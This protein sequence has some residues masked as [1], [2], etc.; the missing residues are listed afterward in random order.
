MRAHIDILWEPYVL[1]V[2]VNGLARQALQLAE[3]TV[4]AFAARASETRA[5]TL[6]TDDRQDSVAPGPSQVRVSVCVVKHSFQDL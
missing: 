1:V 6:P 4:T 2:C 5:P 3:R